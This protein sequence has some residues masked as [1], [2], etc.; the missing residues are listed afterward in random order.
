VEAAPDETKR[1]GVRRN[2]RGGEGRTGREEEEGAYREEEMHRPRPATAV[3]LSC[4]VWAMEGTRKAVSGNVGQYGGG[5]L[6]IEGGRALVGPMPALVLE[7]VSDSNSK[8]FQTVGIEDT[9]CQFRIPPFNIYI[10]TLP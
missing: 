7:K 9:Q 1:R 8:T 2:P 6:R 4:A 3:T 5:G 10:Q